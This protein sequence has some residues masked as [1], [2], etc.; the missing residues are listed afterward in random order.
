MRL[1]RHDSSIH[2]W[3]RLG[4]MRADRRRCE[5]SWPGRLKHVFRSGYPSTSPP[6]ARDSL[7]S[8]STTDLDIDDPPPDDDSTLPFSDLVDAFTPADPHPTMNSTMLPEPHPSPTHICVLAWSPTSV[9]DSI[10]DVRNILCLLVRIKYN[11][12]LYV[13]PIV[14]VADTRRSGVQGKRGRPK[15]E[16]LEASSC[17]EAAPQVACQ[18]HMFDV[19]PSTLSR[20]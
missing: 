1:Q 12:T 19:S 3:M 4:E 16:V 17:L 9:R 15:T 2:R 13:C 8:G 7:H 10:C 11:V 20:T 6:P 14:V 5:C 18:A